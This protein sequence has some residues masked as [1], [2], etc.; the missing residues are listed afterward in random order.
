MVC[1]PGGTDVLV[2]KCSFY[3]RNDRRLHRVERIWAPGFE[4]C[5]PVPYAA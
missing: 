2:V 4:A 5:T 1:P 3:L